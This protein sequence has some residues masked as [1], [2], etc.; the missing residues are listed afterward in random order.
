MLK[1][2]WCL[3][4]VFCSGFKIRPFLKP[5]QIGDDAAREAAHAL[6]VGFGCFVEA[7]TLGKDA[8]LAA[9]QLC[10]QGEVVVAGLQVRIVL[11]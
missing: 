10:L 2:L 4:G 9:R 6:V 3:V 1:R 5:E 7:F 8:V 11:H